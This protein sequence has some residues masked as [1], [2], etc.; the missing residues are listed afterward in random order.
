MSSSTLSKI[1]RLQACVDVTSSNDECDPVLEIS[2]TDGV[3]Q[4][5]LYRPGRAVVIGADE[6]ELD[7]ALDK[8]IQGLR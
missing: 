1:G 6:D 7:T 8:V 4:V 3:W 5:E 2:Y